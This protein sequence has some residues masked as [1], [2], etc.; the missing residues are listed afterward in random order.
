MWYFFGGEWFIFY[1]KRKNGIDGLEDY[2]VSLCSRWARLML[3]IP[4]CDWFRISV[5]EPGRSSFSFC[6]LFPNAFYGLS[7]NGNVR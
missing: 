5:M 3:W 2:I 6:L 7:P 4:K 1:I